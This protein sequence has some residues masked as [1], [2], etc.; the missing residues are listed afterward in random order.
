MLMTQLLNPVLNV[1]LIDPMNSDWQLM[2]KM[3]FLLFL[4]GTRNRLFILKPRKRI[5]QI[6]LE[7]NDFFF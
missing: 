4:I 2:S 5:L 1:S 7:L 6:L 3:D